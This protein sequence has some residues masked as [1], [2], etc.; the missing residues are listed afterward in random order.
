MISSFQVRTKEEVGCEFCPL[1]K[2]P[3]TRKIF[4]E[5]N[6]AKLF[7]WGLA[8][9]EQEND[10]GREFVGKSGVLL[11]QE[12]E[13]VGIE[14]YMCDIQNVVRCFPTREDSRPALKMRDPSEEEI[15]CCSKFTEIAIKKSRAKLHIVFGVL[16]SKALLGNEYRQGRKRYLSE[17]LNAEVLCMWHPSYLVRNG[18]FGA[19]R[20]RP[21][22]KLKRW[23][24]DFAL[25][26]GLLGVGAIGSKD[27]NSDHGR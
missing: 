12:L 11:W 5:V 9:G 23:R 25:A 3:N 14:R 8:P 19:G 27:E 2:V 17:R 21:N 22:E 20:Q 24:E 18:C 13:R 26:V 6:G 7:I 1:D 15:H 10:Q 4:G 16:A